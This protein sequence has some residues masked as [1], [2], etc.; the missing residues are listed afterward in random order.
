MRLD[1]LGMVLWCFLVVV[2]LCN[3]NACLS[4]SLSWRPVRHCSLGLFSLDQELTSEMMSGPLPY[5]MDLCILISDSLV[6][7]NLMVPLLLAAGG[8]LVGMS[9]LCFSQESETLFFLFHLLHG[10]SNSFLFLYTHAQMGA[11]L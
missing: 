6:T 3:E 11:E 9:S 10:G 4:W 5:L 7:L 2:N 1:K 8:E